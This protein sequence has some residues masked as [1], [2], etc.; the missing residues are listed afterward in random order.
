MK[1][2]DIN[3]NIHNVCPRCGGAWLQGTNGI[4]CV[5]MNNVISSTSL[6]MTAVS[7]VSLPRNTMLLCALLSYNDILYMIEWREDRCIITSRRDN[8][9]GYSNDILPILPYDISIDRLRT[10]L[11]FS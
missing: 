4:E 1:V 8:Q 7:S 6:C 3:N 10:L 11:L 9:W 2:I 5:N